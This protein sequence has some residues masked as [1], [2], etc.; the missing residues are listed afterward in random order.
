MMAE[1]QKVRM[2]KV[3]LKWDKASID[4]YDFEGDI[5]GIIAKLQKIKD[6]NSNYKEI[7]FEIYAG[8]DNVSFDIYGYREETEKEKKKRLETT[9][10]RAADLKK[11]KEKVDKKKEKR[12]L[13]ELKRLMNKFKGKL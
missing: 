13:K 3:P 9:K 7:S 10:K 6:D 5:D 4:L 2:K 11:R 1:K 8:Y 12:E